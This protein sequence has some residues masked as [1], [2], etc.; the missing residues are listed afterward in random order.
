MQTRGTRPTLC[1][2]VRFLKGL[3][4]TD[5]HP[6]RAATSQRTVP[7]RGPAGARPTTNFILKVTKDSYSRSGRV[8]SPP[9]THTPRVKCCRY[10][11]APQAHAAHTRH[12][13]RAADRLL[14]RRAQWETGFHA[15]PE[16]AMQCSLSLQSRSL[17]F[18]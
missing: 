2:T 15:F 9:L 8:L 12:R 16:T 7:Q 4:L 1:R 10:H 6:L 13:P 5:E 14:R 3:N 17:P 18:V 11:P